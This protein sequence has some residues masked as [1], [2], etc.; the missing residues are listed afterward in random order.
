MTTAINP[1]NIVV[2]LSAILD[3]LR[4]R[5]SSIELDAL[6][7]AIVSRR[8]AE[9]HPGDLITAEL[10]NQILQDL[11][12][13]NE[14]VAALTAGTGTGPRNG[15]ATATLYDAWA[16]YGSLVKSGEFLPSA[17]TPEAIQSAAEITTY[18]QD[19]MYSALA[20]APL[21]YSGDATGLLDVFRRMYAKQHDVVVL[22]SAPIPGIPDSTD[23]KRFAT[24]LNIGLELDTALGGISLKKAVDNADLNAAIAAQ[25]RINHMVRDE[26]GDVTTGNLEVLYRGAVGPTED[27]VVG[28]AQPVLYK[29]LVANRTN[30]NLDVQLKAEF[31]PPRQAWR[32]MTVVDVGGAARSS[33]R[34]AP[35]D[36]SRPTDPSAI[37]EIRVAAMTPAGAVNGDTGTLQLTAFAP[38]PINR[39]ASAARLLTVKTAGSA[40]TPGAITYAVDS[41]VISQDLSSVGQ[42]DT[43]TLDFKFG[44]SASSGPSSR[45]FRLQLDFSAPANPDSLFFIELA[46]DDAAIDIVASTSTRKLSKAF[47]MADATQRTVTLVI[48]PKGAAAAGASLTFTATVESITDG[49]K[50][51]SP[52]FTLDVNP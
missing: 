16:F 52:S 30:R 46:P 21:G 39:S 25:D 35:F 22:F 33:I 49:V 15:P 8:K 51:P 48:T 41:P 4:G 14:Q 47:T 17:A 29:F 3:Q 9:V 34:L 6:L 13:L 11:Q 43:V 12:G 42:N 7:A 5:L 50:T 2:P 18:L 20:G 32:D 38:Q 40:Q 26:G 27:L 28:S 19:V 45:Q 36:P 31:L 37:Q 44:F 10:M 1:G 23:H 24:L